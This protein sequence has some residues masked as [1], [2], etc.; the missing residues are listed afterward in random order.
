MSMTVSKL[1]HQLAATRPLLPLRVCSFC[2][3]EI[4]WASPT[5]ERYGQEMHREC[6]TAFDVGT[7]RILSQRERLGYQAGICGWCREAS[8]SL[9]QITV[10][11]DA[12][13]C[14]ACRGARPGEVEGL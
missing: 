5:S 4:S 1:A 3:K 13:V 7:Q 12:L 11:F 6:A 14:A 2:E 8:A 9:R 10:P